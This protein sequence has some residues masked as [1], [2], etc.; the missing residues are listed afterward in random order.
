M[1]APRSAWSITTTSGC[2]SRA[3]RCCFSPSTSCKKRPV[4]TGPESASD[5]ARS[6]IRLRRN[7]QVRLH[8]LVAFREFLLDDFRVLNRGHNHHVVAILPVHWRCNAVAVGQLQGVDDAQDL[9]EVA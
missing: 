1:S 7:A 8:R 4:E 9:V 3:T 2:W 5:S 6:A